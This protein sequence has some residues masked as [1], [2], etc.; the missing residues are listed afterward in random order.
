MLFFIKYSECPTR[1]TWDEKNSGDYGYE[2]K[3][4]SE[5]ERFFERWEDAKIK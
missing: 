1:L 5:I 2:F 4:R 3:D